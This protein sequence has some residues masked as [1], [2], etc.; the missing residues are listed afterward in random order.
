MSRPVRYT[1]AEKDDGGMVQSETGSSS[2]FTG[3]SLATQADFR[4]LRR[5][6]GLKLFVR[7]LLFSSL[8]TLIST[9]AQLYLNYRGDV[10][11]IEQRL[12]EVEHSSLG[13]I[14]ASL[15]HVD[16]EQLRLQLDGI[17]RLPDMQALEIR[18][19]VATRSPLVVSVGEARGSRAIIRQ[20]PVIYND[21]GV[22]RNIGTLRIEATLSG[23]Y[24]RLIDMTVI[25]LVSQGIKTFLVSLFTLF[26]VHRLVTRHLIAIA[27]DVSGTDIGGR[28]RSLRL[29][30]PPQQPADELDRVVDAVNTSR[31]RLERAYDELRS[32]NVLLEADI[33]ERRRAD[34]ELH[35]ALDRLTQSNRELE[36]FAYVASHDLQEPLRSVV[37]YSQLLERRYGG[38]LDGDAS[39][40]IE[41]T[42]RAARRMYNLI[43]DLL[44]YSRLLGDQRPLQRIDCD[45]SCRAALDMCQPAI[46]ASGAMVTVGDLP[47][48]PGDASQLALLFEHLIGNALKFRRPGVAPVIRIAAERGEGEWLFSVSDNGIGI[49]PSEQDIFELFRRLHAQDAYPGTGVGLAICRRVVERHGGRIWVTST[50]GAGATFYFTLK[51]GA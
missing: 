50:S 7:I 49:E 47:T 36:R 24:A 29:E 28:S 13:S 46:A 34:C 35:A 33:A 37:L 38:K 40:Y 30:R 26:I 25:I 31:Q 6:I 4:P 17:R 16:A 27:E 21:R 19:T 12:D 20:V 45:S 2:V 5:G 48:V 22:P 10:A 42:V 32:A 1:D 15:W 9:V 23:V 11:A 43:N 18:E 41:F 51:D 14:A 44:G 39:A 3:I 8:I